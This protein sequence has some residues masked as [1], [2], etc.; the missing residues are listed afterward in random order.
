MALHRSRLT[1]EHQLR[2][3]GPPAVSYQRRLPVNLE[4]QPEDVV[5][6]AHLPGFTADEIDVWAAQ[7]GVTLATNRPPSSTPEQRVTHEVY[8]GNWFRRIRLPVSVRPDLASVTYQNGELTVRLPRLNAGQS[9]VLRLPGAQT[10]ER[11]EIPL[12]TSA[13]MAPP[14]PGPH[15]NVYKP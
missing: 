5:I 4:V 1:P 14:G 11:K 9:V 2:T 15:L 10:L 13:D 12:R 8:L 3:A 6:T 7:R